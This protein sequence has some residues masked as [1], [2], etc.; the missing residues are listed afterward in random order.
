[1]KTNEKNTVK[2]ELEFYKEI[3]QYSQKDLKLTKRF[4]KLM[5]IAS[6]EVFMFA[7][8]F[9]VSLIPFM[10]IVIALTE[11]NAVST[12]GMLTI[13]FAI[14]PLIY[15]FRMRDKVKSLREEARNAKNAYD[16]V[17]KE[18]SQAQV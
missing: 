10:L 9:F 2:S 17:V 6:S 12:F 16:A 4:L 13:L 18:K 3:R 1:M 15:R 5:F 7:L 14:Y 8:G 11:K